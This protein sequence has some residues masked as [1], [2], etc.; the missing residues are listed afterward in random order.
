MCFAGSG[1]VTTHLY[2]MFTVQ[3]MLHAVQLKVLDHPTYN[4]DLSL[5]EFY[6]FRSLRKV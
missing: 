4:P 6:T 3:D 5:C 2:A 1:G